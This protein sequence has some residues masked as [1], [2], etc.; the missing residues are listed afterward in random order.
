VLLG[1]RCEPFQ[2]YCSQLPL[3]QPLAF[4]ATSNL[5]TRSYIFSGRGKVHSVVRA[6]PTGSTRSTTL[7]GRIDVLPYHEDYINSPEEHSD[8]E[9]RL[10]L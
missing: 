3:A 9:V 6:H 5:T 7:G 2:R 10:T 1:S 8:R 4:G